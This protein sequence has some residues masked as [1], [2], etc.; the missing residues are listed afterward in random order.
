M[1]Y[2][3]DTIYAKHVRVKQYRDG[4][5]FGIDPVLLARFTPVASRRRVLDIGT[6]SGVIPLLLAYLYGVQALHAVELQPE[7]ADLARENFRENQVNVDL[8][9]GNFLEYEPAEAFDYI[10]SNPPYRKHSSGEMATGQRRLARHESL[11]TLEQMIAHASPMLRGGGSLSLVILTERFAELTQYLRR[12]N[13]EPKRARFVHSTLTAG[14]R[15]CLVEAKKG[16]RPGM[17][18]EGPLIVYADAG[19]QTYTAECRHLLWE[20]GKAPV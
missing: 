1:E 13:L 17:E 2:T 11:M 8:F 20:D 10:F 18:V 9:E 5:R 3:H 15:I 19:S 4:Y 6:G 12:H 14:S 16:A 7:L